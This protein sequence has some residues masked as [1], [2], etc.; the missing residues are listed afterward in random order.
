MTMPAA[1]FIL[2]SYFRSGLGKIKSD[3]DILSARRQA[4]RPILRRSG[5]YRRIQ[6]KPVDAALSFGWVSG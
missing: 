2:P 4:A 6:T 5:M 1:G 3:E